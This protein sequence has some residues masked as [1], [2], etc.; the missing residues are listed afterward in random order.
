MNYDDII[1]CVYIIGCIKKE[2]TLVYF[3]F[4]KKNFKGEIFKFYISTYGKR[5][6]Y[7]CNNQKLSYLLL[8]N[9]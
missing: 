3:R 9:T 7:T 6:K 8:I 2:G 5:F 4:K 1:T